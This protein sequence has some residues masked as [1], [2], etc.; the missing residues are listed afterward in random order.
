MTKEQCLQS[1]EENNFEPKIQ[2]IA[3]A[4]IKSDGNDKIH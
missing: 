3:K 1:Y 4:S 2:D